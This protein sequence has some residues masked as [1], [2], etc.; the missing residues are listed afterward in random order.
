MGHENM[1]AAESPQV[2]RCGVCKV[3]MS[4]EQMIFP[5]A[6]SPFLS[7]R[8]LALGRMHLAW[9]CPIKGCKGLVRRE[10]DPPAEK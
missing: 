2:F 7:W 4:P 9:D 8:E 10:D 6:A 1:M 5:L 3:A